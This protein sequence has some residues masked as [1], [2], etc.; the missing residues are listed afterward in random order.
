M[1]QINFH[2]P[3]I[4]VWEITEKLEEL[5]QLAQ[6]KDIEQTYTKYNSPTRKKEFIA[7]RLLLKS[8]LGKNDALVKK[9]NGKPQFANLNKHLS[10]THNQKYAVLMLADSPCGIDVQKP[11]KTIVNIKTKFINSRDF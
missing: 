8:V 6:E 2:I 3:N 5:L 10:I 4:Y 1:P 9:Q 11:T 7:S